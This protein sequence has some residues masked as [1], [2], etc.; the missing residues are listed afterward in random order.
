MV[1]AGSDEVTAAPAADGP[2]RLHRRRAIGMAIW[3][4]ASILVTVTVGLPG[5]PLYFFVWFWLATIAWNNHRPV[6][7]HLAFAR[8]WLP[9]V[10]LLVAYDFSRGFADNDATPHALELVAFDLWLTGGVLPT[11]WLQQ[12]FYDPNVVHWWDAVG[13][14]VYFSHFVAAPAVA[15]V[16]WLRNRT[17]WAA[18]VRRWFLLTA[19]GLTTYFLYPAAPPWWA[20]KY[21]LI[22]PLARI[23]GR[24]WNAIGLHGAGNLLNVGQSMSNPIAAMPSLH[25]AFALLVVAFFF[26][27]VRRRWLPLL[28][29]Y[30]VA[31]LL[32]LTYSGEHYLLDVFV[33]WSYVGM[34]FLVVGLGERWW[35]QYKERRGRGVATPV[36]EPAL[37]G[38]PTVAT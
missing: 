10:L 33:G 34:T 16:L 28:M 3:G 37:A 18:F 2:V 9:L 23:S 38:A 35:R 11:H 32:T 1:A 20:A 27:R 25:S 19:A 14:W 7:S 8:D 29:A 31:M 36:E 4:A 22:E 30:P 24:G 15:V 12:H 17:V 13:S 26:N 5:A 21:G 6:R